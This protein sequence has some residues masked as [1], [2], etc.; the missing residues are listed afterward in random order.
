VIAEAAFGKL[1]VKRAPCSFLD[2][3]LRFC[4]ETRQGQWRVLMYGI[5]TDTPLDWKL[6]IS[7]CCGLHKVTILVDKKGWKLND[8][9]SRGVCLTDPWSLSK[10]SEDHAGNTDTRPCMPGVASAKRKRDIL[11]E[12]LNPRV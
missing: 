1:K 6:T 8:D 9:F 4:F 11:A 3:S 5:K 2:A 12:R 10:E 7:A